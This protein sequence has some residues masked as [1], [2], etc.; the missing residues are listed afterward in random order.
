MYFVWKG[1]KRI[2]QKLREF[3]YIC[4]N[5]A[6]QF[7]LWVFVNMS[8]YSMSVIRCVMSVNY[9]YEC[10]CVKQISQILLRILFSNSIK[11]LSPDFSSCLEKKILRHALLPSDGVCVCPTPP[12]LRHSHTHLYTTS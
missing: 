1:I 10:L 7:V 9:E 4:I 12:M 5:H 2:A 3:L 8:K 6:R 11:K